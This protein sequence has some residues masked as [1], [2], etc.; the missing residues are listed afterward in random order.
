VQTMRESEEFY[1][2][3]VIMAGP[4]FTIA[5]MDTTS[6]IPIRHSI[7]IA[8][9]AAR[10]SQAYVEAHNWHL[11]DHATKKAHFNGHVMRGTTGKLTPSKGLGVKMVV[12]TF[13]PERELT[14]ECKVFGC[15]MRFEHHITV[16]DERT[17]RATH[18]VSFH[19]W[20]AGW[21]RKTVGRDVDQGLPQT[22]KELKRYL[23]E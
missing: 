14:V 19:G 2:C 21:L 1:S 17:V 5:H 18:V 11:W 22:L 7:D 16:L 3:G 10:L 13:V 23:T 15:R 20:L 6:S 9:S 8:T 4:G 12:T